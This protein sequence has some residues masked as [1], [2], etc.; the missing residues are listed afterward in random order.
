MATLTEASIMSRKGVRY[1]IYSIIAF[2]ILRGVVMGGIAIYKKVFPPA[3]TPATVAFGKLSKLPFPVTNKKTIN[4]SIE[5]AEGGIPKFPA[6]SKVFFMPKTSSNLLSLDFTKDKAKRLGFDSEPQQQTESLYKFYHKTSPATMEANI[7]NGSFSISYDLN[8]DSSPLSAH[9]SL[10][11]IAATSIKSF[12]SS[13]SL[14]PEDLTGPIIHKFLK[15][16]G[17]GFVPALSQS[18][19]NLVRIDLFRKQIDELPAVTNRPDEANIWFMVS[20]IK[21]RGKDVI[22]GEYHYFPADETQVATYP[23]KTGDSAWQEFSSGNYY[24]ASFGTAT[25]GDNIKIRKIYLAYYDPGIYTEFYQPV[26]VFEG[27]KDFVSYVPAV[28][29]DYYGE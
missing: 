12:L 21:D 14:F 11:E 28:T 1:T 29:T 8:T 2:I 26:Y 27:D 15:T 10:P 6:Q 17:G 5:T 9:P 25:D 19:A 23:I 22:A 7:V 4:F 24:P 3:P 20:G 18:D 13:A 16:Q